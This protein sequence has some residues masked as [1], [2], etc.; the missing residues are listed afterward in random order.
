MKLI[1]ATRLLSAV[2]G[3]LAIS[4]SHAAAQAPTVTWQ[5]NSEGVRIE[6][7]AVDRAT[8]YE[9]QVAGTLSGQVQTANRYAQVTSPPAGTYTVAVRG[10]A[11]GAAGPFSVPVTIVVGGGTSS[12]G[13][14]GCGAL[15]APNINVSTS[16][17]TVNLTW[18]Q[19]PGAIGYRVQV[20]STPGGTQ[21]SQDFAGNQTSFGGAIPFL[22]T[23]YVRVL[24]G[25]A[26]GGIATS[27]EKSF[28]IGSPT[29]GPTPPSGGSGPR[30]PDPAPG[31]IL[32]LPGYAAQ[33]VR[34]IASAYH[35]DL[36]NSCVEHGGNNAFLFRVV[37][38][39]RQRDS[40]WGLNWKRGNRG[41]LSQD[42]VTYNFG[43]G[44]DED[45]TNVYITD[46]IGGHCGSSPTW[47]WEDVT[48]K[49][50]EGGGIG[51]WTLQPYLRA[52]LP[53]DPRQ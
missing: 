5:Q 40:R 47:N 33:V 53:A 14:G 49:T 6:W 27:A 35:G 19:V 45:T 50:R 29:P 13:A 3:V 18:D 31:Q 8:H 48:V 38:A 20:G 28:T 42:I 16:G 37:Q 44:P 30:T 34:D 24:A 12:S 25:S 26:C 39:L 17:S 22:G 51:R 10:L 52:G 23:F 32:P 7:T 41:D 46:M 21:L 15:N 1:N 9:I 36:F 4:A 43:S 2:C 11:S